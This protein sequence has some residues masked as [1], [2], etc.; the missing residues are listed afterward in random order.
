MYR[1][2]NEKGEHLHELDGKPLIGTSTVVGVLAKPLTWWASG[3]AVEQLGWVKK[4]DPRKATRSECEDNDKERMRKAIDAL[5]GYKTMYAADYIK[6]LDKAY[7]AHADKLTKSAD[8]GTDMHAELE[9][10]IKICI[11]TFKGEPFEV[12]HGDA[13]IQVETFSRWAYEN[14]NRFIASEAHCYSE[15]LW[16]GGITDCVAEMKD[17]KLVII[18]FKS[19]KEAYQSQFFQVAGYDIEMSENG[20]F[21]AE[22]NSIATKDWAGKEFNISCYIIFP[23]GA[24]QVEPAFYY[25]TV[26]ARKGFEAATVLYKLINQ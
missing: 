11:E 17:G 20:L 23:F 5:D 14:V 4:L 24:E 26:G 16:T 13:P 19:S 6:L 25:D 1:F 10:Y 12:R 21:D 15:R 8:K 18:D 22:G 2:K 7:R 9:K 3:L